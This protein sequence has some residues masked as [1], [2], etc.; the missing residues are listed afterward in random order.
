MLEDWSN[1]LEEYRDVVQHVSKQ[2]DITTTSSLAVSRQHDATH[3]VIT[4][5]VTTTPS[6]HWQCV[7]MT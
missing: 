3:D 6:H 5:R 1:D 7:N 2:P 4:D